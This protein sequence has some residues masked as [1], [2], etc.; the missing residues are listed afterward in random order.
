MKKLFFRDKGDHAQELDVIAHG[1][2]YA[3][4]GEGQKSL[5]DYACIF[6]DPMSLTLAGNGEVRMR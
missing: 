2:V 4:Y 3:I 1:V 5:K 6:M